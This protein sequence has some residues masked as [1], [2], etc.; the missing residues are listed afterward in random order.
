MFVICVTV[1]ALLCGPISLVSL[2]CAAARGAVTLLL[3]LLTWWCLCFCVLNHSVSSPSSC[4]WCS[5]L[6]E[7][8]ALS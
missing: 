7:G 5:L 8:L 1:S 6:Q 3:Q 2:G 4:V